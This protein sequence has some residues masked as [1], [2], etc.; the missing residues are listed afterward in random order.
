MPYPNR[1]VFDFSQTQRP[2]LGAGARG[3]LDFNLV[4]FR[5]VED[6]GTNPQMI[7]V[8]HIR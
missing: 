7:I 1:V 8:E 6:K 5:I 2:R 3:R 4:S